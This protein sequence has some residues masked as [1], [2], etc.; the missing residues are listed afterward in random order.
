MTHS[1]FIIDCVNLLHSKHYKINLK[2]A[3]TYIDSLDWIKAKK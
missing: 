3:E 2:R 1:D